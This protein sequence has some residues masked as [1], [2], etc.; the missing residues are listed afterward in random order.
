MRESAT[1]ERAVIEG[2]EVAAEHW[3]GGERFASAD[4]FEDVSPI[5]EAPIA[6][7]ARGGAAYIGRMR[8]I[9]PFVMERL[10]LNPAKVVM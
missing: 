3:I 7:V 5:D 6:Q 8:R 10:R 4:T 9:S 1:S 2:V